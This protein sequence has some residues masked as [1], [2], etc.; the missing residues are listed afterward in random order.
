MAIPKI[1]QIILM[2]F[3]SA[4]YSFKA[5]KAIFFISS[6]NSPDVRVPFPAK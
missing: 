2:G 1:H 5:L 4:K 6:S 3:R